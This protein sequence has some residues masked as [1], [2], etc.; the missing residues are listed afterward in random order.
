MKKDRYLITGATGMIG[1]SLVKRLACE[2][3]ELVCPIRNRQKVHSIFNENIQCLVNWV[4]APIESFLKDNT[5][6]FD[7]IIHCAS[8]TASLYF[9]EHPV[10]TMRFNT[11]TTVTLLDYA[12]NKGIK[13]MVFLSSLESYGTVLDDSVAINEDFQGYVNPMSTRSSYNMAKRICESFCHAYAEEYDVPAKVV[14][15]TQTISPFITDH[16]KR[17]FAQFARQAANGEDIVL[18]TEGLSARQYIYIE[19]AIDAILC[20]LYKGEPGCVYNAARE[21]SYITI[22]DLAEFIQNSF[23][24]N[25]RVV[26]DPRDD[27]GYAPVTKLKLSTRKLESLGW[28]PHYDLYDMFNSLILRLRG[29]SCDTIE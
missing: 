4:E 16:D 5:I 23:N 25:G 15:L 18:H 22:R 6:S 11:E 3:N 12:V 17:V 8:P 26:F 2:N 20:V 14:R 27:M 13:G 24:T 29:L 7:Y 9:V 10:E 28:S 19:D 1:S 21:D